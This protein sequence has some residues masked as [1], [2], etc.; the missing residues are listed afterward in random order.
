ML[1]IETERMRLRPLAEAHLGELTRLANDREVARWLA[2][3]PH[4]YSLA[5]ARDFLESEAKSF[6]TR[7]AVIRRSDEVFLGM[8]GHG[9]LPGQDSVQIGYWLGRVHWRHGYA[10]EA[11]RAVRDDAFRSRPIDELWASHHVENDASARVIEKLGFRAAGEGREF[12]RASGR[13]VDVR[14]LRL[15]RSEWEDMAGTGRAR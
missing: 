1:A 4:P 15:Q 13:E 7:Y 14:V 12:C 8:A 2:R 10:T 5:D 9:P 3:M 11:A 6:E